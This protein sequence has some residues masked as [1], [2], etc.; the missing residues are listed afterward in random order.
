MNTT[1]IEIAFMLGILNAF[2]F[3]IIYR[4]VKNEIQAMWAL[5]Q[6]IDSRNRR[7]FTLIERIESRQV[8]QAK[9][10]EQIFMRVSKNQLIDDDDIDKAFGSAVLPEE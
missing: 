10:A 1:V 7:V 5:T 6:R 4:W 8:R 3:F 2:G 9:R